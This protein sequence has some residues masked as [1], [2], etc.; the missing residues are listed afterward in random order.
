MRTVKKSDFILYT[1]NRGGAYA[2]Y[3]GRKDKR[4]REEGLF[5]DPD[6]AIHR[7]IQLSRVSADEP[8]SAGK[9]SAILRHIKRCGHSVSRVEH[10]P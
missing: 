2:V 9:V 1:S 10:D 8:T 4:W 5:E 3:F 7:L 6:E